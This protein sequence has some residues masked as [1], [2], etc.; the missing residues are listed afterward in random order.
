M[1]KPKLDACEQHWVAKL[2]HYT[3]DLKHIPG[4]KNTLADFLS[5]DPFTSPIKDSLA[6]F[7]GP[8][9]RS[10]SSWGRGSTECLLL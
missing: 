8:F 10:G 1:I 6:S 4:T 2:V 7:T 9:E 3:F 5:R